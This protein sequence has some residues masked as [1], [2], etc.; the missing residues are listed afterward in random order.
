L[1]RVVEVIHLLDGHTVKGHMIG[2]GGV[3]WMMDDYVIV[4]IEG[5]VVEEIWLWII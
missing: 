4:G 3:I 1:R 5:Q 2:R